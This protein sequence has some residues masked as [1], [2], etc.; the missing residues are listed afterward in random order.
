[1]MLWHFP[2]QLSDLQVFFGLNPK[3]FPSARFWPERTSVGKSG[4]RQL[5]VAQFEQ[6]INQI[7]PTTPRPPPLTQFTLSCH[8]LIAKKQKT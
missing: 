6:L 4:N 3:R 2:E 1:M 8:S 7:N 5:A